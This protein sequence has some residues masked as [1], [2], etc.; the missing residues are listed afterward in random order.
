MLQTAILTPGQ[1]DEAARLESL[2]QET[3]T[4]VNLVKAIYSEELQALEQ[5]ARIRTFLTVIAMRRTR[6]ILQNLD[7]SAAQLE[8]H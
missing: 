2:A 7:G 5:Q 3:E 6:L 1:K 8:V 4:S